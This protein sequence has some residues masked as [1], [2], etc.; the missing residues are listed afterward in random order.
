MLKEPRL[1]FS[2]F[3]FKLLEILLSQEGLYFSYNPM[4][5]FTA[6]NISDQKIIMKTWLVMVTIIKLTQ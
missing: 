3:F 1:I 5:N 4:A 2:T 6:E